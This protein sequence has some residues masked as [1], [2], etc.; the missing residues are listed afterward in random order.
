VDVHAQ[1]GAARLAEPVAKTGPATVELIDHP[2]DVGRV[3]V[4]VARQPW[5]ERRQ[6][7][8]Q[9]DVGRH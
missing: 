1:R 3:D 8:R 6:S 2:V 7:A 5:E 4:D 9:V